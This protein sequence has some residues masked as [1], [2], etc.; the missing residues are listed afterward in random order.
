MKWIKTTIVVAIV[1]STN[2]CPCVKG[3]DFEDRQVQEA[4]ERRLVDIATFEARCD[5][6]TTSG[7]TG[8][9]AY[10]DCVDGF[11]KGDPSTTCATAC[12]VN[13]VSKCCTDFGFDACD[14]FTGKG[15]KKFVICFLVSALF[16]TRHLFGLHIDIHL[17]LT[18]V[19]YC[20]FLPSS[21]LSL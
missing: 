4:Q 20:P 7:E 9:N 12:I 6:T 2:S 5:A 3:Q 16:M 13:G 21:F 17:I 19:I 10:V 14:D 18:L 11:V 15:K 8:S 1:L